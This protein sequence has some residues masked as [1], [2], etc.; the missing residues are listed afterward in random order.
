[1]NGN[2]VPRIVAMELEVDPGNALAVFLDLIFAPDLQDK[3]KSAKQ[4]IVLPIVVINDGLI[5][6]AIYHKRP[7]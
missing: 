6:I 2:Y 7:Y 3:Q 1:M 4:E 5:I